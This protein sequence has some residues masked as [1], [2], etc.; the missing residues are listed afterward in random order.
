MRYDKLRTREYHNGLGTVEAACNT[1]PAVAAN[2]P[3]GVGPALAATL[4]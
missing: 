3:G 1:S 4:S 2:A